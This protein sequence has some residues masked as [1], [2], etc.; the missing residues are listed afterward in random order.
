M[1]RIDSVILLPKGVGSVECYPSWRRRC[2]PISMQSR[3]ATHHPAPA[4]PLRAQV[5]EVHDPR[6][7]RRPPGGVAHQRHQRPTRKG[8]PLSFTHLIFP[9]KT[10]HR[11]LGGGEFTVWVQKA[12][13]KP[14]KRVGRPQE[15]SGRARASERPGA[16]IL[17][18]ERACVP[19]PTT[20][21]RL[22][23]EEGHA[24]VIE[25]LLQDRLLDMFFVRNPSFVRSRSRV[26]EGVP[27]PSSS[28]C[29][30]SACAGPCYKQTPCESRPH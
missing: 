5:R 10:G 28:A 19:S 22:L 18:L 15:A 11:T 27:L 14:H 23:V 17:A 30:V 1:R 13:G 4:L 21:S 26:V 29:S 25:S 8:R 3:A 9:P 6:R 7:V 16:P 20:R 12:F 24:V 2:T